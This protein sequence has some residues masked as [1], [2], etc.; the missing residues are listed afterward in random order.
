MPNTQQSPALKGAIHLEPWKSPVFANNEN[1][2]RGWLSIIMHI[3][4]LALAKTLTTG[5]IH[6]SST[7]SEEPRKAMPVCV[8]R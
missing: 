8:Y 3:T 7:S 4:S 6:S 1:P 2:L 5:E